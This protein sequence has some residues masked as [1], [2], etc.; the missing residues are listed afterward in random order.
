MCIVDENGNY[1]DLAPDFLKNKSVL[2]DGNRMV[3]ERLEDDIVHLDK[4]RHSY[5]IDWRTKEPVLIRASDQW[6]INTDRIK[7]AAI[8]EVSRIYPFFFFCFLST[9]SF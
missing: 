1:T 6:F 3:L 7:D 4:I 5:P 9:K 8:Q 2:N